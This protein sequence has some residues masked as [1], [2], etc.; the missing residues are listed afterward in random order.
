MTARL[1]TVLALLI[2]PAIV[3]A[4]EFVVTFGGDVNFARCGFTIRCF[5]RTSY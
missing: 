1:L 3:Q 2:F 4:Q 5:F